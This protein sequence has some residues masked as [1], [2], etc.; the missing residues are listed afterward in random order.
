[1]FDQE[2]QF[3]NYDNGQKTCALCNDGF[4]LKTYCTCD[5]CR[6]HFCF[7]HRPLFAK[8]W[9]C[10]LCEENFKMFIQ[11]LKEANINE[12]LKRLG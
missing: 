2:K 9:F 7:S 11:P 5:G 4:P 12:F 8:E 3:G 1:M 6:R 10:P